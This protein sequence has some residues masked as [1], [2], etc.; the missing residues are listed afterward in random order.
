MRI[1][2]Q[3]YYNRLSI[4][5]I[6]AVERGSRLQHVKW[7]CQRAKSIDGDLKMNRWLGFIQ[8]SLVADG[9]YT[10]DECISHC[11]TVLKLDS[12]IKQLARVHRALD[13]G[14]IHIF[15]SKSEI[16]NGEYFSGE[17]MILDVSRTVNTATNIYGRVV[18]GVVNG[19]LVSSRFQ[20]R[21]DLGIHSLSSVVVID[22]NDYAALRR[23]DLSLPEG[24]GEFRDMEEIKLETYPSSRAA[25]PMLLCCPSCGKR[26]IDEGEFADKV[27]HTHACQYCGMTWRPAV[28]PTVDVQFLPGFKNVQSDYR[29]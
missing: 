6:E 22:E 26:H 9:I 4:A 11:N 14:I 2:F 29:S 21:P 20:P 16:A 27:H 10:I 28:E 15:I 7:M 23:G 17:I 13:P 12:S 19:R 3:K 5:G 1:L 24:W 18:N 25:I 8:G